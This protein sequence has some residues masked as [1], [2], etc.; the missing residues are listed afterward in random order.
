LAEGDAEGD[1]VGDTLGLDDGLEEGVLVA[2][3]EE[4][5]LGELDGLGA[6]LLTST[7]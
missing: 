5:G 2:D 3:G 6:S 1:A 7:L 4:L